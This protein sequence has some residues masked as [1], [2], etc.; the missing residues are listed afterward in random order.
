[1]EIDAEGFTVTIDGISHPVGE[2]GAQAYGMLARFA[3]DPG[4]HELIITP[5]ASG[6]CY[7]ERRLSRRVAALGVEV[8]DF[9]LGGST[10][11]DAVT[12]RSRTG[13]LV[14]GIAIAGDNGIDA[15]H[16]IPE[17]DLAVITY[18]VND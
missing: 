3:V 14:D 7:I 1:R 5:P 2:G 17:L 9:T 10:L 8:E 18:T 6:Y 4:P 13:N 12:L 15:L 16:G 11:R